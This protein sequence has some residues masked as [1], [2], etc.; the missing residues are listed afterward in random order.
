MQGQAI[1]HP[2]ESGEVYH[3]ETPILV[4]NY[5]EPVSDMTDWHKEQ[6]RHNLRLIHDLNFLHGD[7]RR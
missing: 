3:S 4:T 6:I 5:I 1:P 2:L 7:I